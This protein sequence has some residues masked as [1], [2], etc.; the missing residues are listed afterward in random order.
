MEKISNYIYL[1]AINYGLFTSGNLQLPK[2]LTN[3]DRAN[4]ITINIILSKAV[5]T[6]KI[7]QQDKTIV[8]ET[9]LE[10]Y[11]N[12]LK[13]EDFFHI[14]G[15]ENCSWFKKNQI[16][17][18]KINHCTIKWWDRSCQYLSTYLF[19]RDYERFSLT[20]NYGTNFVKCDIFPNKDFS[21]SSDFTSSI[22][23]Y[24]K[25]FFKCA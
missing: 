7:E 25:N 10:A 13:K 1:A 19:F 5:K 11:R 12:S 22:I 23:Q 3:K 6:G 20:I 2:K 9:I 17:V 21:I 15:F 14:I 8:N 18:T 4:I 16:N 24:I